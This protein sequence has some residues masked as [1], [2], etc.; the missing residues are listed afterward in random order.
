[1]CLICERNKKSKEGKN[2]FLIK[3]YKH[4]FF[5]LGDHQFFKGYSQLVLKDHVEDL[6]DLGAQ[7]QQEFLSEVTE[8]AKFLKRHFKATRINYS[9]LGNVVPHV[10]FHLF[11]RYEADLAKDETKN[12]WHCMDQFEK[13]IVT[14]AEARIITKELRAS[15]S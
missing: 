12:P 15:L 10:H 13:F 8:A 11:P 5:V 3:E 14:E 7:T 6:T 1:M 4:S 9:C 2:P